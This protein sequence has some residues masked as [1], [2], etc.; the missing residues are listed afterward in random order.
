MNA[1]REVP[2]KHTQGESKQ[3]DILDS[4]EYIFGQKGYLLASVHDIAEMAGVSLRDL[5]RF[6]ESKE[7]LFAAVLARRGKEIS[8]G[9]NNILVSEQTSRQ[10]LHQ[11]IDYSI[12]YYHEYPNYGRMYLLMVTTGVPQL[13]PRKEAQHY[14]SPDA[15][16]K[17]TQLFREGQI[18]G[19]FVSGDPVVFAR[20][21]ANMVVTYLS[22]DPVVMGDRVGASESVSFELF[23]KMIDRA[24][25]SL[26]NAGCTTR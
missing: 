10:K 22:T 19:E 4:A 24:F 16:S 26:P 23:H 12:S 5:Y 13:A 17:T 18:S 9:L 7:A 3:R 11:W 15:A 6:F 14:R 20:L 21:L 2:R 1:N 25:C 8:L